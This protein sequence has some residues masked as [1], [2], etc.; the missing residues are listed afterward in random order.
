MPDQSDSSLHRARAGGIAT[1]SRKEGL[2]E[3]PGFDLV[4][5]TDTHV[6][7]TIV[8]AVL[9]R[10][11]RAQEKVPAYLKPVLTGGRG[12]DPDSDPS[13][14]QEMSGLPGHLLT[15]MYA[16]GEP[17][18]PMTAANRAGTSIDPQ[19]IREKIR[20]LALRHALVVEG[21]G[22]VLSPFFEGGH[23]I[24]S[25]FHPEDLIHCRIHLV[26]HPHLGCLSQILCALRALKP[27]SAS[28]L[29]LVRRPVGDDWPLATSLNPDILRNLLPAIPLRV[30]ESPSR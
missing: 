27:F 22:G 8:S 17:I 26:S 10:E 6:G 7:K 23:G 30:H 24:L 14:C 4:L 5:G 18:D 28:C 29:H 1:N 13:R 21:A 16:F 2:L 11:L 15:W 3:F 12:E 25:A 20:F 9:L 19:A